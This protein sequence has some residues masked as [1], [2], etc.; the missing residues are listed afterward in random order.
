LCDEFGF[1]T[2]RERLLSAQTK[3]TAAVWEVE[4]V[5]ITS[6][7]QLENVLREITSEHV[8]S[9]DTETTGLDSRSADLVGYSFAWEVG[10][11]YYV[12]VRSME[13]D[14]QLDGEAVRELMCGV[15]EDPTIRKVGQNIKYDMVVL[16]NHGIQLAGLFVDTMV[17]HYLVEPEQRNHSLDFLSERYLHHKPVSYAMLAGIGKKQV[18][19][20]QVPLEQVAYYAAEDADIPLRL[21]AKLVQQLEDKELLTLFQEVEMPLIA[22]LAELEYN[23]ISVNVELLKTMSVRFAARIEELTSEIFIAA[24]QEFNIDSPKQLSKV[25]FEDMGLPVI[26]KTK[27]GISTD[28]GVLTELSRMGVSDLPPLILEYR[29]VTKLKRTYVDALPELLNTLTGK[30]HSAFKQDVAATGRLSSTDPNLQNIPIRTPE[31]REIRSAFIP[32]EEGWK[33]LAADYSQVELRVLAHFSQDE[34]LQQAFIDDEDIHSNVASEVYDVPVDEVTAEMRRG[35]KAVNFGVIYGQTAFG[36]A[37]A[38]GIENSA[39]AEFIDSYFRKYP[40]VEAFMLDTLRVAHRECR[41]STI[42]GRHRNVANVRDPETLKNKRQRNLAER[43]AINTVIQGSAADII[44]V[45]M[46]AVLERLKTDDFQARLLLQIHDELVFEVA[47]EEVER[48]TA[49]VREEMMSAVELSVPLKVDIC[50][51]DNWAQCK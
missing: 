49:M 9:I 14:V 37:K 25:L 29:Q 39:A 38:L 40:G 34:T 12:P 24:E 5:T 18:T 10:K 32:S 31:G 20:D 30:V 27:T 26:K 3:P 16:R 48:L 1:R 6:V 45:A 2:L 51:G 11:A 33:M 22:V 8:L 7:E 21:Y 4:Y 17:A 19:L 44:K 43:I 35:A 28:A 15:L 41:V 36:L 42:L 50:V 46:I 47:A 23:G 13:G